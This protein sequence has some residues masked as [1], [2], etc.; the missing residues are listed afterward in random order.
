M[1]GSP[2]LSPSLEYRWANDEYDRLPALA[3][4]LVQRQVAVIFAT[5]SVISAMAAKAATTTIVFAT[6]SDPVKFGLVASFG[7]PGA[8]MTG[9]NLQ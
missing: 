5:G 4:E 1:Q 6:G 7:G 2:V 8:N 3:A 9:V